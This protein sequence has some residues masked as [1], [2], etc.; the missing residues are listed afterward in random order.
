MVHGGEHLPLAAELH[1]ALGGVDV[2]VHGAAAD[3]QMEDAAGE[4]AHHLLVL[5]GLLYGGG[6]QG[7]FH[8]AAVDEEEL[9]A[10][11]GPAAGGH[12]HKAGD[13]HLLP[14]GLHRAQP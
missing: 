14:G 2:H 9:P 4:L 13:G 10:P 12:G 1:L 8:R 7:A 6:H 3:V 5:I 11:A